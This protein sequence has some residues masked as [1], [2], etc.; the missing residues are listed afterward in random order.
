M[1]GESAAI[2]SLLFLRAAQTQH[3][4]I[5]LKQDEH[6]ATRN[7]GNRIR[8]VDSLSGDRA[9]RSSRLPWH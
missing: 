8:E 5:Q 2:R 7:P 3:E 6:Q 1:L 4:S 9:F